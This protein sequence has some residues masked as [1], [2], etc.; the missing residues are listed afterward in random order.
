MTSTDGA[1]AANKPPP[2]P[3]VMLRDRLLSRRDELKAALG[4]I[5]VEVFVRAV[6]TS[7]QINPDI[8]ACT[9]SSIWLSC[10]RACRDGLLLD[11]VEAA[12]V[13]YKETASYI[14]MYQGQLRKFRR[15]GQFKWITAGLVRKGE[16]FS[17]FI[18]EVG[19]HFLHVP[20]DDFQAP[21]EKI[22]ALATTKDGGVFATVLPIAEA[23]KIKAM[24]KATRDD[25]PWR[26][27][28]E[29]MYK[30]T[31]LRRL[32]KM[33]PSAR[34]NIAFDD[35]EPIGAIPQEP[36]GI[37]HVHAHAQTL[38]QIA[39]PKTKADADKKPDAAGKSG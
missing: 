5:P 2:P 29:E 23:N 16:E 8:L 17:H 7:A 14:P 12:L 28:P 38:D 35:D 18:D 36:E 22:Y 6:V 39:A 3:M 13:P 19:E 1:P 25:S 33:L 32:S 11:G 27:W 31:A 24:G 9:W 21:I 10:M 20:G 15:S 34:D 4:D 37:S 26:M 30:K